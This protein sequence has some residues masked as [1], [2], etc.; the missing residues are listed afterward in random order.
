MHPVL[1]SIFPLIRLT[2]EVNFNHQMITDPHLAQTV[3]YLFE[4]GA[5]LTGLFVYR[6]VRNKRGE[7]WLTTP[8]SFS[9]LTGGLLGAAAGNKLA[10][11]VDS[12]QLWDSQA[13]GCGALLAGQ[14]IVGGL[15]GGWLG[16]ELG[17]RISGIRGRTGD[18]Y[19]LPIL[20]GIA[21]GRIACFLA[22]LH[23]GTYGLPTHLPWGIDFGDGIPRHP[24]QLYEILIALAALGTWPWWRA[25]FAQTPGLAFR[26]MMLGY[27]LWRVGVDQLKPV[28]HAYALGL[29]GIQWICIV[30]TGLIVCG[31][32]RDFRRT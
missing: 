10:F 1:P 5:L 17:K 9:A 13:A 14:S 4:W 2:N 24:T 26:V 30:A 7:S 19:V 23:D 25:A 27:L 8:G 6:A 32:V 29:S 31:L 18:D 11:W 21:I 16:V 22:G 15:L 28:S 12:P 3:H 20:S